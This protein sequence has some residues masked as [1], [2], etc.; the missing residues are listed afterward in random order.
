MADV[1]RIARAYYRRKDIQDA[2]VSF[3]RSREVVPRYSDS[4][5]K[6][7]DILEYPNDIANLADKGVTSFHCSEE[8]W[9][10]PMDL[11]TALNPEQ[12]NCMRIGWDLI[13][14]LDSDFIE[15]SKVAAELIVGALRFHNIHNISLKF[16]GR[17]GWHLGLGFEA[18]PSEVR[19][20]RIKDLFPQGPRMIASYLQEMISNSLRERILE[21]TD[22][23]ELAR[24]ME[25]PLEYF[26]K[27]GRFN[28]FS[29][30][31]IDTVLISS[32]H[33][34]RMPYSLNEKTG[35]A[36]I[37]IKP[38]Q[39]MQFN[40]G[41]A[42]P[43]RVFPKQFLLKPEQNEAKELM[44]QALDWQK[45][46]QHSFSSQEKSESP[47]KEFVIK[48]VSPDSYPPCVKR[49]MNGM[50]DDGK[51]RA[52]FILINFFKSISLPDDEIRK[53]VEEWNLKNSPALKEGYITSQLSW[54][55]RQRSML[56]PNCDK[57]QYK[58]IAVC[59]PDFFCGKIRNPVNYTVAKS[60]ALYKSS[61]SRKPARKS[62]Y[63][64]RKSNSV[65]IGISKGY[66]AGKSK[67]F[68]K[69]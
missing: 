7:P 21:M 56:P 8:L 66:Y 2:L 54:H 27:D 4:F 51:K 47:K 59:S 12:L 25:K 5:G 65:E 33:L 11:K 17:G 37:V 62:K 45:T 43:E 39:I 57:P 40:L 32:R 42:R 68:Y 50:K 6:R 44:L 19:G 41:W 48:D 49:I 9:K 15:Y 60:R 53:R 38:E 67:G 58:D 52:L 29:L 1:R 22:L 26:Y 24:R 3:S 36:S 34:Y 18:F 31:N 61:E 14:D 55:S 35:L 20:V 23:K 63:P 13:L 28:P 46:H 64:P 16:S 69:A 30:V 10:D